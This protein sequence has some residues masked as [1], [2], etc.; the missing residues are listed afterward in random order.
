[1]SIELVYDRTQEDVDGAREIRARYQSLADWS[2]LTA[3]EAAQLERGTLT[4]KTMNRVASAVS[5]LAQ[6]LVSGGY[7]VGKLST[8]KYEETDAI[9][10]S[11]WAQYLA[12]VQTIR[13][14]FYTLK[15]TKELPSAEDKLGFNSANT[16]EKILA[17]IELLIGKMNEDYRRCGAFRTGNNAVHLPLKGSG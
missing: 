12:N 7:S 6:R 9:S 11:D 15:E 17:D 4:Y 8:R 3:A 14:A 1:M 13:D 16:I 2:G 10:R 5:E